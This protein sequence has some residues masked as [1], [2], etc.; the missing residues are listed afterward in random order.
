LAASPIRSP[1][2]VSQSSPNLPNTRHRLE[3]GPA[4]SVLSIR[5]NAQDGRRQAPIRQG[6]RKIG[7]VA[8]FMAFAPNSSHGRRA[9]ERKGIKKA[10][11]REP[12]SRE[13]SRQQVEHLGTESSPR[14]TSPF[15]N[16]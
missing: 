1:P 15:G 2:P 5:R 8:A 4:W 6:D 16:K 7:S 9:K 11:G 12:D 3:A 10:E 13:V 14:S